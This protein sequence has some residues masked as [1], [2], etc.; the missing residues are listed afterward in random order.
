M[1]SAKEADA[2][3]AAL[4]RYAIDALRRRDDAKAARSSVVESQEDSLYFVE[5]PSNLKKEVTT[6]ER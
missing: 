2:L 1:L 4:E 3:E 6:L 5:K